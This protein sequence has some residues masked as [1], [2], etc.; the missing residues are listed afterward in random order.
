[1]R[2]FIFL[3]YNLLYNIINRFFQHKEEVGRSLKE[4]TAFY[5]CYFLR[6]RA[7]VALGFARRCERPALY[8]GLKPEHEDRLE[9]SRMP[10]PAMYFLKPHI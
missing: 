7:P 4:K 6:F 1:M 9:M 10:W 2:E 5:W 8:A 3:L